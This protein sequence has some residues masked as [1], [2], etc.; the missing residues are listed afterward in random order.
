MLDAFVPCA[1]YGADQMVVFK[2]LREKRKV[3]MILVHKWD[4]DTIE[5]KIPFS[6]LF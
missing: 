3:T 2:L 1:K 4:N 6:S 5:S